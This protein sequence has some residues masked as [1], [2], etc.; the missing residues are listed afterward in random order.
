MCGIAGVIGADRDGVATALRAMVAAQAHRGPDDSG[1]TIVP[2]GERFLGLG[3]RRL[4]ILDL[5][6]CGHQP[7]IHARTGDQIVFNGEIYNFRS[8]R[9]ELDTTGDVFAGHSDTEVLLNGLAR[10]GDAYLRRLQGMYAFAF[11]HQ[12]STSLMLARDPLG[13][14]PLYVADVGEAFLFASEVRAL[15]ASGLVPRTVDLQAVSGYLAY[16]AVQQPRTIV[17]GVS[18]FPP[19]SCARIEAGSSRCAAREFWS[20][21]R[22]CSDGE[23][24]EPD[25]VAIVRRSMEESVADHLVSD[26]PVGVFLSSGLDSTIVAGLAARHSPSIRSF[27]VGF[28]DQPDMS[29]LALA[30]ETAKRF[31]LLHTEIVLN[32]PDVEAI[33]R[34]WLASLDQPSLDG[35]NVFTISKT[36]RAHNITVA[37]SGQGGDELFGGYPSFEDVP[38][39]VPWVRRLSRTPRQM[40]SLLAKTAAVRR[41]AAVRQKLVDMFFT[42]PA[43]LPLY[44]QRRR[45][46]SN[47]QL[48]RLGF[49]P[50]ADTLGDFLPPEA[51]AGLVHGG[52]D[53]VWAISQYETRFYQANTLLRDSDTNGMAHG[54]EI[55]VPFLDQR[56][57]DYVC[58]LPGRI[59]L[60]DRVANKHLLRVAFTELFTPALLR[61]AKRGFALPIRRWMRG[62]M[63]EFCLHS[64]DSLKRSGCVSPEGVD[65]VWTAFVAEPE[66][67]MWARAWELCVLGWYLERESLSA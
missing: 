11:F 58:T 37:L 39:L 52:N 6:P 67:V 46:M 23:C 21:P 41:S 30:N 33:T 56:V 43:V 24:R 38:R 2:F 29:E 50:D 48:R 57:V 9:A 28:A 64:L 66:S 25:V 7:M 8:L 47:A 65:A 3:H 12:A 63:Q 53:A 1:D 4:S 19:G 18:L 10:W 35:L 15:L 22:P 34:E 60:P 5:S 36:V 32:E 26:V 40:R 42:H 62:A 59:R 13:I 16:G 55:R 20:F 54:L 31:G 49:P 51:L 44:L 61:Q 14:K 27:T 17:Q 45:A